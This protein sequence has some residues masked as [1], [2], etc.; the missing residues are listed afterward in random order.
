MGDNIE[1]IAIEIINR[2]HLQIDFE[3]DRTHEKYRA[4]CDADKFFKMFGDALELCATRFSEM[5]A[6]PE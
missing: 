3:N 2:G 1:I 4:F 5:K 6:E